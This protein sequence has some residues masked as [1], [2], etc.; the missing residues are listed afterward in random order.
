MIAAEIFSLNMVFLFNHWWAEITGHF[1]PTTKKIKGAKI[2][3]SW[4][5]VFY[6]D[7]KL[8]NSTEGLLWQLLCDL[9]FPTV[10]FSKGQRAVTDRGALLEQEHHRAA[11]LRAGNVLGEEELHRETCR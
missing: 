6:V 3:R 1:L 11:P 5:S 4:L 2:A 10:H 7:T 8:I 9:S